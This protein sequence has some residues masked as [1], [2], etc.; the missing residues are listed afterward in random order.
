MGYMSLEEDDWDN[1]FISR[2]EDEWGNGE[3]DGSYS[4]SEEEEEEEEEMEWTTQSA[5]GTGRSAVYCG[6]R[7]KFN[8]W[9]SGLEAFNIA[10]IP[11]TS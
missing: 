5:Y 7:S 9:S 6:T 2:E 3:C 1:R 4:P 11:G 8:D 10:K